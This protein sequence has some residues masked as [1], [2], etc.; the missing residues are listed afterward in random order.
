MS[1]TEAGQVMTQLPSLSFPEA[2]KLAFN[3]LIVIKGRSRRSEFWWFFLFGFFIN[4]VNLGISKIAGFPIILEIS[5]FIVNLM[6]APVGIR[7]LHDT[8]HSGLWYLV[9]LPIVLMPDPNENTPVVLTILIAIYALVAICILI[10]VFVFWAKDG[11]QEDNKYGP[12][13]KYVSDQEPAG[14]FESNR[15]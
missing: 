14:E 6:I 7:R 9:I 11:S 1:I 4:L 15:N 10:V 13:P 5:E 2:L 3:K 12:S 8:G